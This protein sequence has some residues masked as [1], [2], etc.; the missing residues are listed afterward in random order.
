[1]SSEGSK[2]WDSMTAAFYMPANNGDDWRDGLADPD[3]Q[4]RRGYSA[5][6]LA[7]AWTAA[8][9]FPPEVARAFDNAEPPALRNLELLAGFPEHKVPLPGGQRASQNDIWLLARGAAGLVSIAVEGKVEE[10]FDKP[11][12]A[13]RVPD[14]PGK[15]ERLTYL[16]GTLDLDRERLDPIAYQLLHRTASALIEAHRFSCMHAVMLVHSFS[17]ART[18]FE[19][20]VAFAGLYGQA[21]GPG[22][23]AQVA[24]LA[25]VS[26]SLGWVTGDPVFLEA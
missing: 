8:R 5:R 10:S 20:F 23:I 7:H 26:L 3:K 18:W 19:D 15:R 17:P 22:Q 13:W 14:T 24:D 6:T 11:V 4:W 16:A 25:G 2:G 9:G 21:P 1:M 12:R